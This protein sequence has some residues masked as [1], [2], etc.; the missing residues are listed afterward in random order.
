MKKVLLILVALFIVLILSVFLFNKPEVKTSVENTVYRTV[1]NSSK[2]SSTYAVSDEIKVI[3]KNLEVPWELVF[4]N[5]TEILLTQ[6]NGTVLLINEQTSQIKEISQVRSVGE[7]G[8]LGMALDPSFAKN[9][10][11]YFYYTQGSGSNLTNTVER[12][13]FKDNSLENPKIILSNIP[14]APNHAGGRI[15]FGP[16][17]YLYIT[18]GDAQNPSLAQN[19]ASLAGKILRIKSD[20]S[21]PEDNPF[22]NEVYSYGHRNPQ[23]IAW[24]SK[25]RLWSTEHGPSG[26]QSGFDEVNLIEKGGNYGWP[27]IK[28]TEVQQDM[29]PPILQSGSTSTWAPADL[30]IQND[31]LYFT[32]LRGSSLYSAKIAGDEL[33]D[34]ST[35]FENEFGRLR[36]VRV[37]DNNLVL[38]TSNRDSRGQPINEDD[39]LIQVPILVL[40]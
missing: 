15:A 7:A 14:S 38:S 35:H 32:G 40:N 20:G 33:V 2:P 29:L 6:R 8:L 34:F 13:T 27:E 11:V 5:D 9:Q 1:T 16:D 31:I 39:R 4:I 3:A 24:D 26:A 21:I 25:N 10:Y 30:A 17:G 28:G 12:Y 23:G 18:T 37:N 36:V 22:G 19:T